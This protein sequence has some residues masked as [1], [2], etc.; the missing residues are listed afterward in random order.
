MKFYDN[1]NAP[2]PQRIR[3]FLAEKGVEHEHIEI[4]IQAGE[5]FSD[6]FRA[7]NPM[8]TVPVLELDDGTRITTTDGCRA[9]LE[10]EYP[11]P[12][13]LGRTAAEKALVADRLHLIMVHGQQAVSDALRNTMEA[14]VD[15]AVVGPDNYAQ[16]DDLA[17]RGRQRAARFVD[18]LESL[19]GENSFVAGDAFSAA[20]ID[21]WI[22]VNFAKWAGVEPGDSHPNLRRWHAEISKRPSAQG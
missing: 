18:R 19:I 10:A 2:S 17:E 21:A 4:D 7:I 11:D 16:I 13:L 9:W 5:Q 14:M 20:D 15:R 6:E 8:C 12:P 1:V 22:F 3:M